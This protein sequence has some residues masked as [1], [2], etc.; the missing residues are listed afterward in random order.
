MAAVFFTFWYLAATLAALP[1]LL[2]RRISLTRFKTPASFVVL[3]SDTRALHHILLSPLRDAQF[4][5]GHQGHRPLGR[6][7]NRSNLQAS[8]IR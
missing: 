2:G 1:I 8:S 4:G 5:L 3:T 7:G 6:A